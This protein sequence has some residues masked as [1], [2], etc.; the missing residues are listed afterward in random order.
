M[1]F[2]LR[3]LG[4]GDVWN[5]AFT[6]WIGRK[7]VTLSRAFLGSGELGKYGN[8]GASAVSCDDDNF[9][10]KVTVQSNFRH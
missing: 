3:R 4:R 7:P 9:R 8:R 5:G 1:R 2:I 6:D 10:K